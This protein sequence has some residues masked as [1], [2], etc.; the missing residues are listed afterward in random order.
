MQTLREQV[1]IDYGRGALGSL[2]IFRDPVALHRASAEIDRLNGVGLVHRRVSTAEAIE[3]EPALAP[4]ANRLAGAIRYETDETG[5]AHRYC[6][7]LFE[8]ARVEG[9][10][11]SFGAEASIEMHSGRVAAIESGGKRFTADQ[12]VVA[13]GSYSTLLMEQARVR[14]PVRPAKGYSITFENARARSMPTRSIIDHQVH[15]VIVPFTSAIRI[16]GTVEF[17]GFDRSLNPLRIRG[18]LTHMRDILPQGQ[19]D[20]T[21][22]RPWCGLRPLSPDGVAIIGPTPVAN[23]WV[24][25]GQGPLGWT[26]AAGA[27]QLL[28][29]LISG[30]EPSIDPLPYSLA[31]F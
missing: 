17:A 13:A 29:Q 10:E 23:L 24:N 3:L 11:F 2:G 20:E 22:G 1:Q 14:L 30:D 19:W 18:L 7:S 5:D 12:Y 9:V 6:V 26:C 28:T 21:A 15:I 27:A 31:R 4:F 25:S 16:A 8:R